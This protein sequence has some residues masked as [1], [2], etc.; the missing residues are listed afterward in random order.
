MEQLHTYGPI[1]AAAQNQISIFI[2]D[3]SLP[4]KSIFESLNTNGYD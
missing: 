2:Q 3:L 1:H 4:E